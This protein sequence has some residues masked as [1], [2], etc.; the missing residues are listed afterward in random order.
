MNDA[1]I[2]LQKEGTTPIDLIKDFD[3]TDPENP[4]EH[5]KRVIQKNIDISYTGR[6]IEV[7][8]LNFNLISTSGKVSID[9]R[10]V[11][12]Y[13]KAMN[14]VYVGD[15]PFVYDGCTYKKTDPL[16]IDRM[17]YEAVD[18]YDAAPFITQPMLK[19]IAHFMQANSMPHDIIPPEGWDEEGLYEYSEL[20][21]FDNGLYNFVHDRFLRFSSNIFIT[22]QLGA[23]YD[24]K[25]ETHP[26]EEIYKK[27]L[28][29]P[30]TRRFFFEMVGYTLFSTEMF[31]PAIFVIYGP[32]HTGKTALQRAVTSLAGESNVSSLSLTQISEDF[33][34]YMMIGKLIN[35]CGETGVKQGRYETG[36][37]GELLKR[38]SDGQEITVQ[39]KHGQPFQ[40]RN[41]AKLWFVTN[42]MPD[43]GDSS[44]GIYRRVYVM[45]CRVEQN[46][47]DRIYDK[48]TE[49][50]ALTWLANKALA[51][52]RDF[53]D[54]GRNF[55]VSSECII[56]A[57]AYKNQDSVTDFLE[58][59]FGTSPKSLIP[60]KLDGWMVGDLY[61][62]YADFT[63][64]G[65]GKPIGKRKFGEKI[66]NEYGMNTVSVHAYKND[67]SPTC[68]KQYENPKKYME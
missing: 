16:F 41:T 15:A 5:T 63:K 38:L 10:N 57:R 34:T 42:T 4:H 56:E 31:P 17:I 46:D 44:S 20:I 39:K 33:T 30:E 27:I 3:F 22:H 61:H 29:N 58:E 25:I 14:V 43:F 6:R 18:K 68:K 51:G 13:L 49:P 28:P 8:P 24:P 32:G 9:R 45:P 36:V 21:P 50:D 40:V 64:L 55:H 35:I 48:L 54:N 11:A 2:D 52:Y 26:V 37:D 67:G 7:D 1:P 66:R 47:K 12:R 65:G 59:T 19:D 23:R 60:S 62:A 53:L